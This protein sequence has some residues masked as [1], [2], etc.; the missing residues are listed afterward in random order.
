MNKKPFSI[1]E[2]RIRQILKEEARRFLRE[3][4]DD[5]EEEEEE[6]A[7]GPLEI[8]RAEWF[9]LYNDAGAGTQGGEIEID[10]SKGGDVKS[11]TVTINSYLESERHIIDRISDEL[12]ASSEEVREALGSKLHEI[13]QELENSE[14]IYQQDADFGNF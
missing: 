1:S 12:G 11:A 8:N 6:E 9:D 3:N 2:G 7:G 10:Y 5:E 14:R 4:V 13:M